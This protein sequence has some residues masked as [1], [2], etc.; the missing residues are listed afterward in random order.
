MPETWVFVGLD[1]GGT[2]NNATLLDA[3][4]NFLVDRLVET[5]S[6][7]LEGPEVAVEAL[8]TALTGILEVT[9]TDPARVRAVGLDTPGPASA[10]GV[11]S[12]RGATNFPQP[13]WWGFD[14]RSALEERLRLPVVY[15]NDGNAAALYAHHSHFGADASRH[16]SVSAIVGTGL[17]GGVIEAGKVVKGAAGMAGELGHVHIP[18]EGLLEDAQPVPACNCSFTADAESVASLTGIANNLLPYWLTRFEGHP[19][20]DEAP[21][22]AAKLVRGYGE[23]EDPLAL[24]IFEQQA[25]ALGRLFTIAANFTDPSAYFVGGGV[26]ETGPKFREW[27]LD[28]VRE[29]TVLREEQVRVAEFSLVRDLDM[30]GARGAAI[31]ARDALPS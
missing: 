7:V 1:N 2:S 13:E 28:K 12:S 14:I 9:G 17:G 19:L 11:I 20:A 24:K 27:F 5:P 8:A 15:N 16:S 30:A 10:S 3:A 26:V 22:R 23:K 18:M 25:I 21:A 6:R 4:G 29:H 31:A